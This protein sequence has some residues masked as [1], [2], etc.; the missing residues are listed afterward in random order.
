MGASR[1]A[2]DCRYDP[3]KLPQPAY[4]PTSGADDA[5]G[6]NE[7]AWLRRAGKFAKACKARY[8]AL[9]SHLGTTDVVADMDTLRQALHAE[10]ISYYGFSYGTAIGQVYATEYPDQ[11]RRMI[12]DGN[13][14]ATRGGYESLDGSARAFEA[15]IQ[16]FFGW[17]ADHDKVYGLG[18][19]AGQVEAKY[20][21][22]E[23]RLTRTP[24]GKV[25][26][27][28]FNDVITFTAGYSES[29]W[30]DVASAFARLVGGQEG[31]FRKLAKE[32]LA[33]DPNGVAIQLGVDC[34]DGR[35]PSDYATWREDAFDLAEDA[36]FR[37]WSDALSALPCRV[38][39]AEAGPSP[40]VGGF[41]TPELLLVSTTGDGVTPYAN[42]LRLRQLF[43]H[44]ILLAERG[45]IDHTAGLDDNTC[46]NKVI[47]QYLGTG[48]LPDRRLLQL[49][50]GADKTCTSNPRPKPLKADRQA[51][52]RDGLAG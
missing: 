10:Q 46:I 36:P 37:A 42:S 11:V 31:P 35:W 19:T 17:V 40:D 20:Y 49:T 45:S 9:L 3:Y 30:P 18:N 4:R 22:Q 52:G 39:P 28:D 8:G 12:L 26:P 41:R 44:S 24:L 38:W 33:A 5:P 16:E 7:R 6:A 29:V 48:E 23:R 13:L 51:A 2:L 27:A 21:A 25:G 50:P 14:D 47:F 32:A 1:P 15:S 43:P 34:V